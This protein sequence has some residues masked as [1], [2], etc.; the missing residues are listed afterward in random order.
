MEIKNRQINHARNILDRAVYILPRVNQLWFKYTYMEEV[1]GNIPA[2]RQVFERW[3]A[4]EPEEQ[5]WFTYINFEMRYQELD[6]AR[7]VYKR[8]ITI[9]SDIKNWI[10]FAKFEERHGSITNAREVYERAVEYYGDD[11]MDENLLIS[12]AKF[13][14]RQKE[15]E[16]VKAIYS[17]GLSRNK[18]HQ[19]LLHHFTIYEKKYGDR[20]GIEDVLISKRKLKYEKILEQTPNDY[21]TWFDYVRLVESEGNLET[22]RSIYERA[23]AVIP[24]KK[25]KK[26]W[27][28]YIYLWI[29][30]AVFEELTAEDIDRARQVYQ[31]CLKLI[32]HSA[33]TFAKVWILAAKFEIRQRKLDSGRKILGRAIGISPKNKIFREYID[34]EILLREFDRCR[35]LYKKW[36]EFC[37]ENCA[38]WTKFAELEALLG[39]YDR[40]RSIYEI[41][42]SQDRLD[43]PEVVWKAFIDFEV[44]QC[45]FDNARR[46]YE[47]LLEKTHHVKVWISYARFCLLADSGEKGITEARNIFSRANK[48]LATNTDKE[49]R[50]ILLEEWLN[51]EKEHGSQ[52]NV[53]KINS[54]M[55]RKVKKRRKIQDGNWEEYYDYIFPDS[56]VVAPLS[57]LK[58]RAKTWK[59]HMNAG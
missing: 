24:P 12:F 46:L 16:R 58:A 33:F 56:E 34:I 52:E 19:Q 23:V 20:A 55:P 21:D 42:I 54:L 38:A 1:L 37:P 57:K 28:R 45:E 49:V 26:F 17:Y 30:Y 4:W 25:S 48:S 47:R 53:D 29:Y 50:L 7:E 40:T 35:E 59:D 18:N 51:F 44:D 27:R 14:E 43:M 9:Y 13:E 11:H 22:I 8:F 2:C 6:R 39:E 36:I 32:P 41:A 10:K 15:H 31:F 5:A 3:M